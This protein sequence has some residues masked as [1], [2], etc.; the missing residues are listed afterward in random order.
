MTFGLSKSP[1]SGGTGKAADAV[2]LSKAV[3]ETYTLLAIV[4]FTFI[5]GAMWIT[6]SNQAMYDT[7][8]LGWAGTE[9]ICKEERSASKCRRS[10]QLKSNR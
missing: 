7:G 5:C 10:Q 3:T 1:A 8:V 9:T 6:G 4:M 2:N